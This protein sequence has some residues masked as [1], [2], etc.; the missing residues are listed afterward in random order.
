LD[1]K[2]IINKLFFIIG[3]GLLAHLIFILTTTGGETF[4]LIEKMNLW[5]IVPITFFAMGPWLGHTLRVMLWSH[6]VK[7]AVSFKDAFSIILAND[8]GSAV[9]PASVGGGPIKLGMLISKGMSAPKATFLVLLSTTEDLVFYAVGILVAFYYIGNQMSIID[10]L[11]GGLGPLFIIV[12]IFT[13]MF[14]FSSKIRSR[15]FQFINFVFRSRWKN[16]L[17]KWEAK[18]NHYFSDIKDAYIAILKEGKMRLLLSIGLLFFQWF[19]KFTIF[20]LI[21]KSLDIPFDM[22]QTYIKQWIIF[23]TTLLIPTPGGS[24]GAEAGFLLMFKDQLGG[25]LSKVLVTTWR[26]FSY[27]FILILSVIL[28]NILNKSLLKK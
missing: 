21:L 25:P 8:I 28:F 17:D 13:L 24:G 7:E 4:S 20:I 16:K 23:I 26:F 11:M 22:I 5:Y 12:L 15:F 19:S 3:I 9:A 18:L 6:F 2:K 27:Y 10:G 1:F 14:L